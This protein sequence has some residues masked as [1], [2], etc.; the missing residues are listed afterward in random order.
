MECRA[1]VENRLKITLDSRG[2]LRNTIG[3]MSD[4]Q[5]TKLFVY[6]QKEFGGVR[7]E[8]GVMHKRIDSVYHLLDQNLKRRETDE[9]ERLFMSRQLSRHEGWFK[10]IA[11]HIRLKLAPEP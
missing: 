5:F 4:D 2:N 7:E 8:M 11:K 6:I 9:Q 3:T 10:Q 1:S